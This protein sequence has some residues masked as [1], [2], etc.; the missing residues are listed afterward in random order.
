MNSSLFESSF[1]LNSSPKI[2]EIARMRRTLFN[3]SDQ[4]AISLSRIE[5]LYDASDGEDLSPK[6]LFRLFTTLKRDFEAMS[7]LSADRYGRMRQ[8]EEEAVVDCRSIYPLPS[9]CT[10]Y[11]ASI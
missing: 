5:R 10:A 3:L 9:I 11:D 7:E 6:M 1:I 4:Q 8:F 2:A